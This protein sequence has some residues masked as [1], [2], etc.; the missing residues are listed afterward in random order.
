MRLAT[1]SPRRP[2]GSLGWSRLVVLMTLVLLTVAAWMFT[3]QQAQMM[4][5]PMT[6]VTGGGQAA[7]DGMGGMTTSGMVAGGWSVRGATAFLAI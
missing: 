1:A 4:A 7:M 5:T 6:I 2:V 3:I